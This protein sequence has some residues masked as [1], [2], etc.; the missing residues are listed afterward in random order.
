MKTLHNKILSNFLPLVI[1]PSTI[2]IVV[3]IIMLIGQINEKSELQLVSGVRG[4]ETELKQLGNDLLRNAQAIAKRNDIVQMTKR[5]DQNALLPLLQELQTLFGASLIRVF[6]PDGYILATEFMVI[7]QLN[8]KILYYPEILDQVLKGEDVVTIVGTPNRG[9]ACKA[10]VPIKLN[11]KPI[12]MLQVGRIIDYE[13]LNQIKV[14]FGIE[15]TLYRGDFPQ[16]STFTNPKILLD[17]DLKIFLADVKN[18]NKQI[19][20]EMT[21]GSSRY[22]VAAKP[23]GYEKRI[24]GIMLF[25]LPIDKAFH[26]IRLLETA[27]IVSILIIA[28]IT[29]YISNRLSLRIVEPIKSL[30]QVTQEVSNGSLS[31]TAEVQSDDEIGILANTFNMM[32]KELKKHTDHLNDLVEEKTKNLIKINEELEIEISVRIKAEEEFIKL[33][34]TLERRVEEE[35]NHRMLQQQ[36]LIQQSKL[37]AMG[38]M[39]GAIAHQWR[40]PLNAIGLIIQ[41]LKSAYDFGELDKNYITQTVNDTMIQ[42]IHMSN[43]INDFRN[44]FKPSKE[45]VMF[46]LNSTVIEVI[47]LIYDQLIKANIKIAIEYKYDVTNISNSAKYPELTTCEPEIE[48]FGYPNEFKQVILNLIGNARDAINKKSQDSAAKGYKGEILIAFYKTNDMAKLEIHDSGGGIPFEIIDKIFE[49]YFST[50]GEEGTGIGLYMSKT[51]IEQNMNG[52]IYAS[53]DANGAVF[54]IELPTNIA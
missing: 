18:Q 20:R 36:L 47:N 10:F 27:M 30:C 46:K 9:V 53:N 16:A 28:L 24:S 48:V 43:T 34:R 17:N 32:I 31:V 52:K 2:I 50:K 40:Q 5:R 35:T 39:I 44:F 29:F 54:V 14:K 12:G 7:P 51:I 19:I 33:H 8:K 26:Q 25:A 1:I 45:K 3:C 49:Q 15:V 11:D 38:E 42:V 37:A 6:S 23:V 21:L 4:I 22:Y 41:D 13:L